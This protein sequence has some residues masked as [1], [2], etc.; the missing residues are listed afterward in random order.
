MKPERLEPRRSSRSHNQYETR[1][2]PWLNSRWKNYF[3]KPLRTFIT[4]ER[5][6]LKAL[7]KNGERRSMGKELKATFE[8]HRE[9]TEGQAERS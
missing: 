8:K 4:P 1:N 7:P 2:S 9:E 6:L 3:M 5:Q